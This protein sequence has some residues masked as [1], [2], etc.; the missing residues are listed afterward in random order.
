MS[1]SY[2]D[3]V[4]GGFLQPTT[5]AAQRFKVGTGGLVGPDGTALTLSG[6]FA[7]A[8]GFQATSAA[9]GFRMSGSL[10]IIGATNTVTYFLGG[11]AIEQIFPDTYASTDATVSARTATNLT[12]ATGQVVQAMAWVEFVKAST[13][14]A[15]SR[16]IMETWHNNGGVLTRRGTQ[17]VIHDKGDAAIAAAASVFV[18]SGTTLRLQLTGIAGTNLAWKSRVSYMA[19]S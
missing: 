19:H 9:N 1:G 12:V 2:L 8:L 18:A 15:V 3:L 5:I 6:G 13:N 11:V 17:T 4:G 7:Q 14:E 16:L 10:E